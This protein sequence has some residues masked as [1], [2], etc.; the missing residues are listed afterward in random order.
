[1][2]GAGKITLQGYDAQHPLGMAFDNV[3]F[4]SLKDIQVIAEYADLKFGPGA[5]NL[6]VAGEGVTVTGAASNGQP[7]AC[8]GKFVAMPAR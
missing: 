3:Q 1:L 6:K 5:V 4:D 7:N 8:T 2:Q